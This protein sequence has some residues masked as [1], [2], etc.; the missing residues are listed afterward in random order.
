MEPELLARLDP[1][2][3]LRAA[4]ELYA[5]SDFGGFIEAFKRT[6]MVLRRPEDYGAAAR[7]LF[8]RL[9]DSGVRYAEITLSAGVVLWRG[10]SLE[11]VWAA[12]RE[13]SEDAAFPVRWVLDAVRQ[14]GAEPAERVA[15]FAAMRRGEGIVGFGIGGDERS[16]P[17]SEFARAAATATEAGLGF[18]PH[19]GETSTAAN[20][21]EMLALG[22]RRIGHGIRAA[23][24]A[25]LLARLRDYGIAL[26]ICPTSNLRTGAVASWAEHPLRRIYEAGVAVSLNSDDPAMF[27]TSI[28]GEYAVAAEEF[29]FSEEELDELARQSFLQALDVRA[30]SGPDR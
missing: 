7:A 12:V 10:Q 8:P 4:E 26:E 5:F 20:V 27:R 2:M 6:V 19:A 15:E 3:D 22:A 11:E 17:A 21:R 24:D 9:Y 16:T 18:V 30:A 1:E 25:E 29:G 13:A 14:H 23:E 28:A